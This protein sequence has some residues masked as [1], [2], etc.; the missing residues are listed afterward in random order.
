MIQEPDVELFQQCFDT[1][2]ALF[3][4]LGPVPGTAAFFVRADGKLKCVYEFALSGVISPDEGKRSYFATT[5][6]SP[7]SSAGV[8]RHPQAIGRTSGAGREADR[9][10]SPLGSPAASRTG[11]RSEI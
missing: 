3:L 10:R 2:D 9:F 1:N 6:S 4:M 8:A 5:P 11:L 7:R